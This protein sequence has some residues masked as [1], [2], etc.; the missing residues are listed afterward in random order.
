MMH[1]CLHYFL[2]HT[3]GNYT[4]VRGSSTPSTAGL[5]TQSLNEERQ[6]FLLFCPYKDKEIN[7]PM[8]QCTNDFERN[9]S[10][11]VGNARVY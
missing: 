10:R 11:M 6:E 5:I 9:R 3:D 4:C 2:A 1:T 8:L 7:K